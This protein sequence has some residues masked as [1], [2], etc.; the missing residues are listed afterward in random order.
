MRRKSDLAG[1]KCEKEPEEPAE[2]Q[3]NISSRVAAWLWT[4]LPQMFMPFDTVV[5]SGCR[6]QSLCLSLE[7]EHR[8]PTGVWDKEVT[9]LLNT[10][11][12]SYVKRRHRHI[13][14]AGD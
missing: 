11:R 2:W 14:N 8:L 5:A 10:G 1:G 7:T 4:K 13:V 12:L 3:G 9:R 6:N